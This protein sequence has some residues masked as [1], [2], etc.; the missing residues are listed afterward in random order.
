MALNTEIT[1]QQFYD[2]V[3]ISLLMAGNLSARH[4][5]LIIGTEVKRLRPFSTF[6]RLGVH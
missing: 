3:I 1:H 4:V 2:R 6:F 5:R